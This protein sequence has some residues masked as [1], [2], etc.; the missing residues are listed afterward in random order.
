[1]SDPLATVLR[2]RRI[3]VDDAKRELAS[4]LQAEDAAQRE[5]DAADALIAQEG[6]AAATLA[7]GDD[8][9]EAYAAWLPVGR[10]KAVAARA[11]YDK[12]RCDVSVARAALTVARAAAE[13]AQQLLT[14]RADE[15]ALQAERRSQAVMDEVAT[16]RAF[17]G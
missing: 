16:R 3:T 17:Y 10:A 2:I 5:A 12:L 6:R 13:V 1:M 7:G 4:L 9:V 15:R 8:V 14:T 11:A